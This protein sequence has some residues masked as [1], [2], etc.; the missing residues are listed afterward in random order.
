MK[1]PS[2]KLPGLLLSG[3]VVLCIPAIAMAAGAPDLTITS[4]EI[5]SGIKVDDSFQIVVN[6]KNI[7]DADAMPK[8]GP[9][10]HTEFRLDQGNDGSFE[11]YIG[12]NYQ[13]QFPRSHSIEHI[14]AG[15]T[16]RYAG[17]MAYISGIAPAGQYNFEACADWNSFPWAGNSY[18][19]VVESNENNNCLSQVFTVSSGAQSG[20]QSTTG[21]GS[22][23]ESATKS[24]GSGVTSQTVSTQ[25]ISAKDRATSKEMYGLFR[26]IYKRNPTKTEAQY[27]KQRLQDKPRRSDLSGAMAYQKRMGI[28]H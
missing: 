6:I 23:K 25:K 1:L 22:K 13:N 9:G 28:K 19:G 16:D 14:D 27:W 5:P 2:M 15:V 8:F 18:S 7:G 10:M 12:N 4:I 21:S 3:S 24:S 26:K 11:T 20:S 17:P